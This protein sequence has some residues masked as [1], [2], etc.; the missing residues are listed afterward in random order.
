MM[1]RLGRMNYQSNT[2]GAKMSGTLP[3]VTWAT[4]NLLVNR[5]LVS[6]GRRTL[7][8]TPDPDFLASTYIHRM[9][10]PLRMTTVFEYV[11][12]FFPVDFLKIENG[13]LGSARMSLSRCTPSRR[14]R[15]TSRKRLPT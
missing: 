9:P 1:E 14:A 2:K 11:C 3:K 8:D 13:Y 4:V 12:T 6:L 7:L 10:F 15:T 5:F